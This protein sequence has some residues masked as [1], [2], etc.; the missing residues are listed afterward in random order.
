M[1]ELVGFAPAASLI[2]VIAATLLRGASV[3]RTSGDRPWAFADARGR[4]RLAGLAFAVSIAVIC[5]AAAIVAIRSSSTLTWP[6]AAGA[7]LAILGAVL[8]IVAQIQMGRAWRVGVRAGDAP[9][10]IQ[11][12]LFRYSRNPIFVGMIFTG[13]GVSLVAGY[14]WCWLALAV[15]IL[16]CAVQVTIEEAHLS[17]SFG[18]DYDVFRRTVPRWFGL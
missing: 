7:V 2:V 10:F 6:S 18:K 14:W 5:V 13:L 15:F 9:V 8:V 16:A 4:Q 3:A 12:G 11:H 1:A 17:A